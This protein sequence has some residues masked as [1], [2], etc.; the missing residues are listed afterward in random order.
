MNA[1]RVTPPRVAPGP[2][3]LA[4]GA[5][6]GC[7]VLLG[8]AAAC[9]P[10]G[11]SGS[12]PAELLV[13]HLPGFATRPMVSQRPGPVALLVDV[14]RSPAPSGRPSGSEAAR[15][16][17]ARLLAALPAGTS[18]RVHALGALQGEA[19][20]PS[21]FL[22]RAASLGERRELVS[23]IGKLRTASEG[24]LAGSLGEVARRAAEDGSLRNLRLVVWTDFGGECGGDLCEAVDG[25][26]AEG[27]RV[28]LV[29]V[30][31][32][33]PPACLERAG[34]SS[35]AVPPLAALEPASLRFRVESVESGGAAAGGA[36]LATGAAGG[37][38]LSLVPGQI[39]I[40][41]DV[42]PTVVAG[43]FTLRPGERT[44]IEVVHFPTASPPVLEWHLAAD[45]EP[46]ASP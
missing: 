45:D 27:V 38:P 13:A 7:A 3:A 29:A 23:R 21:F 43:P 20:G 19:C 34:P 10:G 5:L 11:P 28:D 22:G 44:R 32:A 17:A 8:F 37:P 9:A 26:L 33:E 14:S 46:A 4:C 18:A 12:E 31:G 35:D 16:G 24:S 30:G 15:A 36:T 6:L 42:D 39:R 25:L 40:V 2:I 41:F 1:R